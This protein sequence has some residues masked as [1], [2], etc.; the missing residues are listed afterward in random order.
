MG[1]VSE[2]GLYYGIGLN[3]KYLIIAYQET[4]GWWQ[5]VRSG[6]DSSIMMVARFHAPP[7]RNKD[8]LKLAITGK[9][10]GGRPCLVYMICLFIP[11]DIEITTRQMHHNLPVCF[12]V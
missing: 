9:N 12:T 7:P 4:K 5:H 6:E 11:A 8:N 3:T 2:M 1:S 10:K